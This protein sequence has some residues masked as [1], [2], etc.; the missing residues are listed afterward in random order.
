M[1]DNA[2][3]RLSIEELERMFYAGK[4]SDERLEQ[5]RTALVRKKTEVYLGKPVNE[6]EEKQPAVSSPAAP[7]AKMTTSHRSVKTAPSPSPTTTPSSP[8][9][10]GEIVVGIVTILFFFMCLIG[11]C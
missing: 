10:C 3:D 5:I 6:V 1:D 8:T 9:G 11:G 7:P 4:E 2:L